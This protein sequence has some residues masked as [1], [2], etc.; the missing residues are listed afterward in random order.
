MNDDVIATAPRKIVNVPRGRV[1]LIIHHTQ[2]S[3]QMQNWLDQNARW[4]MNIYILKLVTAVFV[5]MPTHI[6]DL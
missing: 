3:N 2:L 1:V 6:H 5:V 4:R